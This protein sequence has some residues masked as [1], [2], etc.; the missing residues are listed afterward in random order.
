MPKKTSRKRTKIKR[1]AK[2]T[3]VALQNI[4]PQE[5]D[6]LSRPE[7]L[8]YVR[9]LAPVDGCVFCQARDKG[10]GVDSLC[11]F[12]NEW[13][14]VCLNKYPYN[15]GH[16]M[17]L[18]TRHCGDLVKLNESEFIEIQKVLKWVVEIV[19]N[20]Y[21]VAGLNVGLNM[22]SIAGAGLPDH[23]HWHV[24]PRWHGDTNFFPLI[25]ETKVVPESLDQTFARYRKHM[26]TKDGL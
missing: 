18:P 4:W 16:V 1:V 20:E 17:I 21:Q 23:L 22:G 6:W 13:A 24:I 8:K 3:H 19:Q 7:R 25:A 9:K 2:K 5:R 12:K 14:M 15:S 10:V 11:V 26:Q